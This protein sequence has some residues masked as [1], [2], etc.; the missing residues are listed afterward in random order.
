VEARIIGLKGCGKTTLVAALAE[1][2]GEGHIATVHVGDA[3]VRTLSEIFQPKK[4]T[5]AEFKVQEV[6]WPEASARKGEMERYLD[7]LA[8]G[9]LYLHV[10]RAFYS[11]LLGESA[12]PEADLEELDHEFL[13]FDLIRI[14]RAFER[15]KKAPLPDAGKRALAH[16][17]EVLEAAKPLREVEFDESQ[18]S[19]IRGYQFLTL[20]PQLLVANTESEDK[21]SEPGWDG[22]TL[23]GPAR[24]R[25]MVAFPFPDALEVARLSVEEQGE[26]AAAMGLPG[27]AAEVVAQAAFAQLGLI[28]FLTTGSDEV[29]AWPIRAGETAREAAGAIHT[30]IQRGFIRAEVVS[31]ADFMS[32]G[33]N[34][35][36]CRDAGVLR[37]EGK[38]YIVADG[39]IV[40]FRFNV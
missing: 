38:D 3:R 1:G 32:H 20:T 7:A 11:A 10:L 31:F 6:A 12:H 34:M 18:L 16:C 28:S 21:A 39:D 9:Q 26:Y 30:D 40:N 14:E 37:V 15:A 22:S 29:R 17:Q 2:R 5:F 27:P 19:F 24:G 8:G 36:T 35:K 33:S 4:T 25:H 13:L 23:E